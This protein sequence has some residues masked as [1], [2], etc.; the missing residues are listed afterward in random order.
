MSEKSIVTR[1]TIV[2]SAGIGLAAAAAPALAKGNP[3]MASQELHN[4][5]G[6]YPKPPYK[7][8]SQPW[9]GLA[10]KMDPRPDHGEQCYR[11]SGRLA[12]RKA[13]ITGGDSGMGRAG[14][15]AELG[16]IHV[17]LAAADASFATGQ[18]YGSAGGSGQP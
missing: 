2:G 13:L 4:P 3:E 10:S 11:G 14:Q 15:P 1:R 8:Q 5:S 9:P 7:K 17:Q 18:V 6:E 12:G 16:S